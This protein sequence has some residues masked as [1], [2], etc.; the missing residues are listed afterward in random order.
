LNFTVGPY[1]KISRKFSVDNMLNYSMFNNEMGYVS[2]DAESN[3]YFGK[4]N[5]ETLVN[6]LSANYI[7]TSDTY[8]TFRLRHYWSKADYTGDYYLLLPDGSLENNSYTGNHDS[9]YNAFN[10]DMVYTWR[11]APGSE[12]TIGWKNAIYSFTDNVD[13]GYGENLSDM[14]S[15]PR[16]NSFSIKVLYYLDY[17]NVVKRK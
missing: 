16:M 5:I 11:F 1:V 15:A 10:I 4:R 14:F 2:S 3:I 17:Q 12:M 6:T 13:N 7:F 8:L 9:N